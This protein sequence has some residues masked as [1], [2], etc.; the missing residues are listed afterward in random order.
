MITP[1][2]YLTAG[3]ALVFATFLSVGIPK[4]KTT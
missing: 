3:S 4:R 2:K 1:T